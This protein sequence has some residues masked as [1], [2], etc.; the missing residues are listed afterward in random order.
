MRDHVLSFDPALPIAAASTPPAAW[1][2]DP[3]IAVLER[4][5]VFRRAWRVACR[6]DQVAEPGAYVAGRDAGSGLSWVVIRGEDGVLRALANTCRHKATEVCA[7]AGRAPHLTCPYHGW[8]YRLDGSLR[9]APR[10]A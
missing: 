3:A 6:V 2:T 5:A 1:Y 10:M 7:G 8:T 9:T 4:E